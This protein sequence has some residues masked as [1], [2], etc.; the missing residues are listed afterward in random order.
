MAG[1]TWYFGGPA[2]AS[3][4]EI[5][6]WW[7]QRRFRYN[8][9]LFVVGATTWLLV[10]F[11]GS[12]SVKPGVDFEEPMLML[13]GP[14]LYGIL[15]NVA[16]TAGPVFDMIVYRGAPLRHLLRAGYVFLLS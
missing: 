12:A 10:L 8:R 15:A 4:G 11:A 7:E 13:I 1:S 9:D 14:P 16:Y 5:W 3:R 6:R 2:G